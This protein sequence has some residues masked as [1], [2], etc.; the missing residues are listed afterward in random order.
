MLAVV[1]VIAWRNRSKFTLPGENNIFP[2]WVMLWQITLSVLIIVLALLGF[3]GILALL[4]TPHHAR[5]IDAALV[6]IGLVDRYD[7]G[8]ALLSSRRVKGSP[9]QVLE[10]FSEGISLEAWEGKRR[11]VEDALNVHMV[12]PL[13]YGGRKGNNRHRIVLTVAPG[14]ANKQAKPLYDDDL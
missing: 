2:E 12:E 4:G 11:A 6:H 13:A 5:Q 9:V 8:P 10:L 14:A 3:W 7:V 1:A